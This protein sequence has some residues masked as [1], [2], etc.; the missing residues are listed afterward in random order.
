MICY[1]AMNIIKPTT[2]RY[3]EIH[4]L[5]DRAFA[6]SISESKLVKDLHD[7]GKISLD[8]IMEQNG[9]V[10]AY[11]CYSAAY[12]NNKALIGYHLAPLAVLPEKQ[13]QGLGQRITR[14]S[15]KLLPKDL[16]VYVLGDPEYYKQFGFKVDKTQKC[17]SDPEGLHFM[18]L[19]RGPLPPRN[20]LYEEEFYELA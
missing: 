5:L 3:S 1:K 14:E 11:I 15:L 4:N 19:S 7:K 13:R 2:A 12:D 18:V 8:L 6:G 16:T 9:R 10:L 17:S 20:V